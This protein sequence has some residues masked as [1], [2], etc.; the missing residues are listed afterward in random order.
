M[1]DSGPDIQ[2]VGLAHALSGCDIAVC[3]GTGGVGKTTTAAAIG[4]AEAHA[5]K[6][7]LVLTIDPARRLADALG[8]SAMG[9]EEC[10]ITAGGADCDAAPGNAGLWAMMLEAKRTFDQMVE[11]YAPSAEVAQKIFNNPFYRHVSGALGGSQEYMAI[12]K[13]SQLHDRRRYD[14]IVLDT[15]PGANALDFFTAPERMMNFL[16]QGALQWFLKPYV[17][18]SRFGFKSFKSGARAF[19]K[20]IEKMVG[21]EVFSD[22]LDFFEGFEGMYEG[23][24]RRAE[25]VDR[26]LRRSRTRFV[27]VATPARMTLDETADFSRKLAGMGMNLSAVVINRAT[28]PPQG[29]D[30]TFME[31][32]EEVRGSVLEELGGPDAP[33]AAILDDLWKNAQNFR[34]LRAAERG[35]IR[36]FR[37]TLSSNV[38]MVVVPQFDEDIH[39]LEGLK[40]LGDTLYQ[41]PP[42]PAA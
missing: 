26:I 22:L 23:F 1:A 8:I 20:A 25:V 21:W 4:L 41:P 19:F 18:I 12:E 2:P 3:V 32:G 13:L 40:K 27:L 34:R 6:K 33:E 15:P 14:L 5:G 28:F 9:N 29:C 37:D 11:K 36:R 35:N 42:L 30:L 39:S 10:F 16:D 24:K 7:V 31:R 17:K 38:D